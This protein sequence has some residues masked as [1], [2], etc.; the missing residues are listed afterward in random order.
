MAVENVM[1]LQIRRVENGF[2]LSIAETRPNVPPRSLVAVT[3]EQV[4]A[5]AAEWAR[6]AE[7][8]FPLLTPEQLFILPLT[9]AERVVDPKA[10]GG[11]AFR[12]GGKP[13]GGD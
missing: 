1:P 12:F 6:H 13:G 4:A 10:E 2:I 8:A 9:E 7:R 5:V 11:D 3:A